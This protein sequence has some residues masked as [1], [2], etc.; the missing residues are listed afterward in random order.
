MATIA[1]CILDR[2]DTTPL[3]RVLSEASGREDA[4]HRRRRRCLLQQPTFHR[5]RRGDSLGAL[6][7]TLGAPVGRLV[8]EV[9]RHDHHGDGPSP[10]APHP[11]TSGHVRGPGRCPVGLRLYR[12]SEALTPWEAAV[13]KPVPARPIPTH[14]PARHHLP[15]QGAP[16]GLQDPACQARPEPC[17]TQ[18]ARAV[19]RVEEAIRC[20]GPVGVVVVAAWELAEDVVRL[21]ARRRQDGIRVLHKHRLLDTVRVHRRDTK[22]WPLKRPG[23]QIAVA[24]LGPLIPANADRPRHVGA[25]T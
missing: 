21:W 8:D 25:Q 24:E 18:R 6:D 19:D 5:Q 14:T 13:A 2:A 23:P 4:V 7:A 3:A 9:D 16:P 11:V 20:Q 10:L 12:R 15:Q 1:R 17:R 22:G